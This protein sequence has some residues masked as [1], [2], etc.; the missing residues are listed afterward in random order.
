MIVAICGTAAAVWGYEAGSTIIISESICMNGR[1]I[2]NL[3]HVTEISSKGQASSARR[4]S[5]C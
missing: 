5:L 4:S 1:L 3:S 2:L